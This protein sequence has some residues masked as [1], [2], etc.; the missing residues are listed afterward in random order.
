[1][2]LSKGMK[3]TVWSEHELLLVRRIIREN[4]ELARNREW[5][6]LAIKYI[7]EADATSARSK[8]GIAQRIA[9]EYDK[10]VECAKQEEREQQ[11]QESVKQQVERTLRQDKEVDRLHKELM[12]ETARLISNYN[13]FVDTAILLSTGVYKDASG[14]DALRFDFKELNRVLRALEPELYQMRVDEIKKGH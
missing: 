14:K 13:K 3:G 10:M 12:K 4:K 2:G 7:I 11:K 5:Q 6:P 9:L 8:N 1:M